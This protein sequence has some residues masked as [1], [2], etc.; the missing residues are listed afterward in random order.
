MLSA[1]YSEKCAVCSAVIGRVGQFY[2]SMRHIVGVWL[3]AAPPPAVILPHLL[4][5]S[6]GENLGH[7][8]VLVKICAVMRYTVLFCAVLRYIVQFCSVVSYTVLF[9]PGAVLLHLRH[10]EDKLARAVTSGVIG[11]IS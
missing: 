10:M 7:C 4:H 2:C 8:A 6:A 11:P 5:S 9:C 1:V 3:A